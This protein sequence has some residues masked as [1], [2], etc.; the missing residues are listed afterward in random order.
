MAH[1]M[2]GVHKDTREVQ[3][4]DCRLPTPIPVL[5]EVLNLLGWVTLGDGPYAEGVL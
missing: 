1:V 3:A 4:L 2:S 5:N